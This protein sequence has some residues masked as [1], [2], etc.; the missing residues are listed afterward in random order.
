[1]G[2]PITKWLLEK[3]AGLD[4]NRRMP[5]FNKSSF[6]K[7]AKEYL[8]TSE[9]IENPIDKVAYFVD[10]YANYNDHELGFAVIDV[11]RANSVEVILPKQL[12]TPLPSIVYGD[13]KTARDDLE[14]SVK[15]LSK[16]VLDGYK[17]ICSEP[18]AALCLKQELRHFVSGPDAQVVSENT[19]ELMDYL[20]SL[21]SENKL[22]TPTKSITEEFVYHLP[23]HLC[24]AG[25]EG[26][27][28]KLLQEHCGI[29]VTDLAAGCCGIAGTFGMQKKNAE[30]SSKIS[31]NLKRAL[32]QS[33]SQ[34]VLTEC[35][36]CKMQI[37]HISDCTTRH[38]IKVLAELYHSTTN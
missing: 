36:A 9:P 3:L 8:A 23:C 17:I 32:E 6:L 4:K 5:K 2:L 24:A 30:L 14:Y 22:K 20:Y 13:T 10:T 12:P 19:F 18:S 29:Q 34:N 27:S 28:I 26:A 35:A 25:L 21:H 11:L 31:E 7:A 15:H 33:P 16:A 37:E 38:P 1:M